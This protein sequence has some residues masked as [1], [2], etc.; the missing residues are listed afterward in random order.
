MKD[1]VTEGVYHAFVK[2]LTEAPADLYRAMEKGLAAAGIHPVPAA[3]RVT[4]YKCDH[5][6][7]H[8]EL[9]DEHDEPI[10]TFAVPAGFIDALKEAEQAATSP[11]AVSPLQ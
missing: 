1:A 7:L 6:S 4:F 5:G 10:A 3:S 2:M 9:L 11:D 8:V